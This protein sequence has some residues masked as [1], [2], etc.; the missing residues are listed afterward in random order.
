V[1]ALDPNKTGVEEEKESEEEGEEGNFTEEQKK[2]F[3]ESLFLGGF[4]KHRMVG[5]DE[6]ADLNAY[7]QAKML[8]RAA[9][10]SE[11]ARK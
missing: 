4:D 10:F 3:A 5:E 9:I 11:K 8:K 1:E 6:Y 2:E 7:Q